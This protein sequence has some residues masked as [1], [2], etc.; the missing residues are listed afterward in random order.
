MNRFKNSKGAFTLMELLVVIIIIGVISASVIISFN[1]VR[2]KF[3]SDYYKSQEKLVRLAAD[4]YVNDNKSIF[5]KEIGK[6]KNIYLRDLISS[7]YLS[8]VLDYKKNNC[9]YDSS[10]VKVYRDS[11]SKY[12]Y[13]VF[14][15]CPDYKVVDDSSG[16]KSDINIIMRQ[17]G[18]YKDPVANVSIKNNNGIASYSYRIYKNSKEVRNSGNIKVKNSSVSY[19]FN[20]RFDNLSDGS[21][22]LKVI[23]ID[24]DGYETVKVS[25]DSLVIDTTPPQCVHE[26]NDPREPVVGERSFNNND[27]EKVDSSKSWSNKKFS[28]RAA[29]SDTGSGCDVSKSTQIAFGEGEVNIDKKNTYK[30]YDKAG[31]STTCINV[32]ARGDYVAPNVSVKLEKYSNASLLDK[33]EYTDDSKWLNKNVLVTAIGSDNGSGVNFNTYQYKLYI[34]KANATD[35]EKSV[36]SDNG[37]NILVSNTGKDYKSV[38]V[39]NNGKREISYSVCDVAGNCS[40]SDSK[41]IYI[42]KEKPVCGNIKH[43]SNVIDS[44]GSNLSWTNSS[45][46]TMRVSCKDS[47]SGC[48]NSSY[49]RK[50]EVSDNKSLV[51][52]NIVISDNAGN[53]RSCSVPVK[54][55]RVKPS[56]EETIHKTSEGNTIIKGYTTGNSENTTDQWTK[57]DRSVRA[58]CKDS[59][60][61]CDILTKSNYNANKVKYKNYYNDYD[62]DNISVNVDKTNDFIIKDKAG[63]TTTCKNVRV[64]VDKKA[65]SCDEIKHGS[66]IIDKNGSNL[67][68]TNSS[69]RTLKVSCKDSGSGC[70]ESSY[71]EVFNVSLNGSMETGTIK[72]ED[73]VGN[74]KKCTVFVKI[75]RISP[76]C[77]SSG[78]GSNWQKGPIT[79]T[80]TCSDK[81]GSGCKDAVVSKKIS[82]FLEQNGYVF[83]YVY[84]NA[85]NKAEC[86]T[87]VK[88]DDCKNT[89][90]EYK[91]GEC[92]KSCG[93]GTRTDT[94]KLIS[95]KSGLVC[96]TQTFNNACNTQSC[97]PT[98]QF[99]QNSDQHIGSWICGSGCRDSSKCSSSQVH[100]GGGCLTAINGVGNVLGKVDY[101]LTGNTVVF[102]WNVR[103]G[104]ESYI[105]VR[106]YVNFVIRDGNNNV[107]FSSVMKEESSVW[108]ID[109]IHSGEVSY[110]FSTPGVYKIY[111][112]GN[113]SDPNFSIDFGTITVS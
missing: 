84:D 47:M 55:D 50:F 16:V 25:S 12:K 110:T 23:V 70:K 20:V 4:N 52:E 58:G 44:D 21:Y 74:T 109:S 87:N 28:L 2:K 17:N 13:S 62:S 73:N 113:S 27:F 72:I 97:A 66:D 94:K 102:T 37:S 1:V 108:S 100:D 60:S 68:W 19:S 106:Y 86:S 49:E 3:R 101:N 75:D 95:T 65:P 61:G 15:D 78:G 69:K 103:Q 31:N 18:N 10:Y 30:I 96:G 89:K 59:D 43:D 71:E 35:L 24:K 77:K 53:T 32:Y 80:G 26:H 79:L 34:N 111:F 14:L 57:S 104:P 92:S 107:V 6:S 33:E 11:K 7:E 39:T 38:S 76:T 91:F 56:C 29:C 48:E 85:G 98:V 93:G 54:I 82:S 22:K 9:D 5:P 88:V 8:E 83:R 40:S 51:N 105:S 90:E 81:G 45:S 112:E 42:D 36:G 41:K 46:R 99:I 67:S 64:R 63:N